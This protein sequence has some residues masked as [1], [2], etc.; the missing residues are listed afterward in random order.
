[1]S[2]NISSTA[3]E[4]G[5]TLPVTHTCDGNDVSP[6]LQ[7]DGEPKETVSFALIMED[8]DSPGGTFTHWI[9]YNLPADCHR[10]EK[11]ANIQKNLVNGGIQA[12]NDFGKTGY[13]GP[14][15]PEG[16]THRYFFRIFALRKKLSPES[17]SSGSEFY[18]VL[19]GLVLD[20]AEYMGTF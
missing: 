11:I 9:L 3:F 12:K 14:C 7:W 10:L 16:K 2:L 4:Y 8:P 17:I 15:P 5:S 18:R 20:K 6:P 19:N 1:M 13:K